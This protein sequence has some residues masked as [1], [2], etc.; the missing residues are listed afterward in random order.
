VWSAEPTSVAYRWQ[1][2]SVA[3]CSSIKGA[4]KLTLRLERRYLGRSVR[5]VA[6][7]TVDGLT[8]TSVSKAIA[9]R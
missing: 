9:V 7:A 3:S 4:T 8:V 5:I 2:C 6:T 1:L